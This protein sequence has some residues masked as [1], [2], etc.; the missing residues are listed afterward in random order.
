MNKRNRF[1][2]IIIAA[3]LLI[4]GCGTIDT[5]SNGNNT[6]ETTFRAEV[7]EAGDYLLIAPDKDSSEAKSSDRISVRTAQAVITGEDGEEIT[8]ADLKPGDFIEVTYDGIMMDSYPAQISAS[9]IRVTGHNTLLDGYLALI[10]DIWQEDSGLNGGIEMIVLDTTGWAGLTDME[11]E[12][13]F[14][15]MK[16]TYGLDVIEGTYE[17]MEEQGLIDKEQLYFPKG[18]IITIDH[19]ELKDDNTR[20]TCSISKWRSGLG[21]V[22]SEEAAAEWKDGIWTVTKNGMWI[23]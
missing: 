4:T 18:V 9:A 6:T 11:K 8:L 3:V 20:I 14:A 13:I 16:N 5:G 15:S 12:I 23:S 7:I 1:F 10:D 22:G 19:V 17:E 2:M 21:A